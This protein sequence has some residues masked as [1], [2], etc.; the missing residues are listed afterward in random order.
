MNGLDEPVVIDVPGNT[1]FRTTVGYYWEFVGY[2]IDG[3]GVGII[4]AVAIL[5]SLLL[6]RRRCRRLRPPLPQK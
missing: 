2:S 5:T 4:A 3:T 6:D 1:A